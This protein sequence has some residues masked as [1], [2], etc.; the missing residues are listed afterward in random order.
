[1]HIS[2][3]AWSKDNKEHAASATQE[4]QSVCQLLPSA[5]Q[6]Q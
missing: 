1:M 2:Q 4:E 3:K 6:Q 5:A